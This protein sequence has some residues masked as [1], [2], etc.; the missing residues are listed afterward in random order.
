MPGISVRPL[1]AE[2]WQRQSS[3]GTISS[4]RSPACS[5]SFPGEPGQTRATATGGSCCMLMHRTNM[6]NIVDYTSRGRPRGTHSTTLLL[7][8]PMHLRV[9]ASPAYEPHSDDALLLY[10]L[11][12]AVH[13][14]C[15]LLRRG[16]HID[17]HLALNFGMCCAMTRGSR[18]RVERLR[19]P[20]D[21]TRVGAI[22]KLFDV[23]ATG[24]CSP[25]FP[26]AI[27]MTFFY[28]AWRGTS[29]VTQQ[30]SLDREADELLRDSPDRLMR[31][32]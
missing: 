8:S 15:L 30:P 9:G 10:A 32:V 6:F 22:C 14:F 24:K 5:S 16:G 17:M 20:I 7:L 1:P 2:K 31:H 21:A 29:T 13:A 12:A 25:S 19:A 18:L 11:A 28:L 27:R 23:D 4:T 26:A 3:A